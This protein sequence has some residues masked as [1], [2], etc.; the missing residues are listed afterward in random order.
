[1]MDRMPTFLEACGIRP[2]KDHEMH[3]ESI[4]LLLTNGSFR[5]KGTLH[6]EDQHNMAVREG[7]WKLVHQFFTD[8]PRLYD[9]SEDISE[10][11]DLADER[12]DIVGKLMKAHATWRSNYY[13]DPIPP[14][15][16]RSE[17]IFPSR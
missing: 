15:K 5:R 16:I 11:N 13:H 7:K 14:S 12:P 8:K 4:L 6:W 3:G 1:M 10:E 9:L 17:F 2:E